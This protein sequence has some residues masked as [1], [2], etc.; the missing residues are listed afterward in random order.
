MKRLLFLLPLLLF[1]G[2]A[3][4]FALGLGRNTQ[5]IPS[6]L[7]DRPMPEFALPRLDG[8]DR[9]GLARADLA[10]KVA[11]VNVFASWCVPCR[12]EHPVLMRIA[13]EGKIPLYGISWKD[14]AADSR[15]FLAELGNP[16]RAVGW[17]GNGRVGIDWGVYGVPETYV[18]GKDGRVRYRHVSPITPEML[19]RTLLPLLARLERE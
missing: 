10:G 12:V 15:A 19:E 7:I 18:I 16:Y 2:V 5:E 9:P 3:A 4:Y 17:D 14:K 6:A 8:F 11:L 13:E 1:A